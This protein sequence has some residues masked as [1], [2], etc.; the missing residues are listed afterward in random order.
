MRPIARYPG[1]TVR[2]LLPT[3]LVTPATRD[4]LQAR[5]AR[6]PVVVP[7]FFDR[8]TF[9]RLRALCARLIPQ[10]GLPGLVDIAGLI[11]ERLA[12][13]EGDGWRYAEMPP[14]GDA[15][16]RG[17]HALDATARDRARSNFTTLSAV[18]QDEVLAA[19]RRGEVPQA[20][21]SGVSPKR[22]FEEVLA[23][24]SER[25]YSHP[26]ALEE[27]GFVGMADAPGWQAVGLDRLEE[28]EPREVD[29]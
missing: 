16:V 22:F 28:R 3:A 27:I 21:W 26:Y 9:E 5:L 7:R 24:V 2:A 29:G 6:E 11:D 15:Y 23:E 13:G 4:A 25:F 8:A 10:D 12:D 20:A 18:A 1:G 14:D 19:V 17:L